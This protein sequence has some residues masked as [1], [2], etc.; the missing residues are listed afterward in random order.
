MNL[1][2]MREANNHIADKVC[3]MITLHG[4]SPTNLEVLSQVLDN[5]LDICKI[6]KHEGCTVSAMAE[7]YN[8]FEEMR[9]AESLTALMSVMEHF[10][11]DMKNEL[12]A[13]EK[14]IVKESLTD[15][16]ANF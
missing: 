16:S 12:T 8:N 7:A 13:N 11:H 4:Y 14:A 9:T 2:K 5:E 6:K 1:E 15:M 3:E 10:V